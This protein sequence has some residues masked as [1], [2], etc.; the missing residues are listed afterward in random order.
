MEN[1]RLVTIISAPK[2][3]GFKNFT[4]ARKWAKKNIVG[5]IQQPE[6][7]EVNI[8]GSAIEKYLSQKAVEQSDNKD[9]HLSALR[10]LPRIIEESIVGKI[11][12][13]RDNNQN[14]RDIVRLY[15]A[16]EI[17]DNYYRVKTTV[18]RYINANEKTK[19]YSY[20]VKEIELLDGTPGDDHNNPLPRTSN[21]SITA[22]KL[23]QNLEFGKSN[24]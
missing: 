3:H 13:D 12:A 1:K 8:T 18:K 14:V 20:E 2:D 16:I 5:S 19:A 4:E 10:V 7:G 21:N 17:N 6:I 15:G 24:D 23:L 22:A 11:H 9:V